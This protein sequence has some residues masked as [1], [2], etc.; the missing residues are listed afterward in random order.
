MIIIFCDF[1]QLSA[2]IGIS[3]KNEKVF[4]NTPANN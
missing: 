4:A 2:K 1:R 3:L